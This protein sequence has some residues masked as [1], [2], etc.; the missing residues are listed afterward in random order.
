[1]STP[2]VVFTHHARFS[3]AKKYKIMF[4]LKKLDIRQKHAITSK[5]NYIKKIKHLQNE[6]NLITN[7]NGQFQR[8][9]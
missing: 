4:Y 5:Y 7:F 8:R 3:Y 2:V 6:M 9:T 1:M